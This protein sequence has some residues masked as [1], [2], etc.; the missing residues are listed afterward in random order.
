MPRYI[1]S[2]K[3]EKDQDDIADYSLETW[4]E[5]QALD[6]IVGLVDCLEKIA[7]TPDIGRDASE[8][9]PNLKR[10]NYKAH[11]VFYMSID[12][13]ILIVRILGQKQDFRLHL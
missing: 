4:G 8:F 11:S 9:S 3:A 13:G 7:E 1:L 12:T 5:K 10:F 2:V 6:Y